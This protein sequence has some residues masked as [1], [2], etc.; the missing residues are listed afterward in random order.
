MPQTE[1][2][3]ACSYILPPEFIKVGVKNVQIV[4]AASLVAIRGSEDHRLHAALS[5][6]P[7]IAPLPGTISERIG[8]YLSLTSSGRGPATGRCIIVP[9]QNR[10]IVHDC[11]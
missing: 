8:I 9:I 11:I 6:N 5:T 1:E 4:D 10:P 7:T 2:E 3:D